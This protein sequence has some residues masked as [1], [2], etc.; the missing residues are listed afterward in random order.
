MPNCNGHDSPESNN[1]LL[2]F[3]NLIKV[4]PT[5][6]KIGL[7]VQLLVISSNVAAHDLVAPTALLEAINRL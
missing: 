3:D 1:M 6:V 2:M 5:I 4:L 7:L